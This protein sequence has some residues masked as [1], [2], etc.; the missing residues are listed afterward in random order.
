MVPVHD[1][2]GGRGRV[3]LSSVSGEA[4][5]FCNPFPG[6]YLI[7]AMNKADR[8]ETSRM[9]KSAKGIALFLN[10]DQARLF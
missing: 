1:V 8:P 7:S 3:A 4:T 6:A 10:P 2:G 9:I 5:D